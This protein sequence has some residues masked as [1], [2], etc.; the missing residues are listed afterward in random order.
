[1][2]PAAATPAAPVQQAGPPDPAQGP[3][4][5]PPPAAAPE[6]QS[7]PP[8]LAEADHRQATPWQ[9]IAPGATPSPAQPP[10]AAAPPATAQQP[11]P[12]TTGNSGPGEQVRGMS[13]IRAQSGAASHP[14]PLE[15]YRVRTSRG[16]TYDF[17]G[18]EAMLRWL[19]G[20][21]DI[22]SCEVAEPAGEWI[23]A[24]SLLEVSQPLASTAEMI[25]LTPGVPVVQ[26][27][28]SPTRPLVSPLRP[29]GPRAGAGLWTLTLLVLVAVLLVGSATATRYGLV[30]LGNL[31]PLSA[32]GISFPGEDPA[33][34]DTGTIKPAADRERL[35]LKA[36]RRAREAV[37]L[38]QYSRA[39][40]EFN[41]ALAARPGSTEALRG[42][43][44]AC[45]KLG[46]FERARVI[47]NKLA[48]L[49]EQ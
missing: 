48:R 20:R 37:R 31:P 15:S 34:K 43:A 44:R 39:A 26:Q 25:A 6:E 38:R 22:D 42:L 40:L 47:K 10:P 45:E 24:S 23:P 12:P 17:S 46:D 35:Y 30:N 5:V 4:A 27:P 13:T 29:V 18:R 36:M 2:A 32:L 41:R 14:S 1:M 8:V 21:D 49:K 11:A 7:L 19:A 9:Q 28:V 3:A 33:G 16:L